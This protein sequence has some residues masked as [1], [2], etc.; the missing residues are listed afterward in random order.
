MDA[1]SATF[2][3]SSHRRVGSERFKQLEATLA[4]REH[5]DPDS[6]I[7]DGLKLFYLQ[8]KPISP[9]PE[10]LIESG[11]GNPKMADRPDTGGGD[12]LLNGHPR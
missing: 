11:N 5:G 10:R 9:E 2:N 7:R 8:F 12:E 4:N 3:E 1:R 6:L